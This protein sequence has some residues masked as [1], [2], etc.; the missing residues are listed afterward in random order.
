M[1]FEQAKQWR[2]VNLWLGIPASTLAAVPGATA[3]SATTGRIVA[4]LLALAAAAFGGVPR[5]VKASHWTNQ[6]SPTREPGGA[7]THLP[8]ER[9]SADRR[10][11][12]PNQGSMTGR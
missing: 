10:H 2:R 5:T 4:G 12:V 7:L 11:A 6:L 1:Q 9:I 3:V 8:D